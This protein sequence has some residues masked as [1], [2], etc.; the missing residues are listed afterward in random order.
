M[1]SCTKP[2]NTSRKQSFGPALAS[3]LA[4]VQPRTGS[5]GGIR[6]GSCALVAGRATCG[7]GPGSSGP[8]CPSSRHE[9]GLMVLAPGPQPLVPVF[10][11]NRYYRMFFNTLHPQEEQCNALFYQEGEWWCLWCSSSP[12]MHMRCSMKFPSHT[13][14]L[15]F[16]LFKLDL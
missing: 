2:S 15:R 10:G 14:Y 8:L 13:S 3:P 12:P 1:K 9:P 11:W 16:F 5:H 7:I 4:T 6:P